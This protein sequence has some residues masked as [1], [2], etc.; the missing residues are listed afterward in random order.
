[1]SNGNNKMTTTTKGAMTK[2]IAFTPMNLDELEDQEKQIGFGQGSGQFF[3]FK[4]GKNVVRF[5]PGLNGQQAF[6]PFF[7]HFVKGAADGKIYSGLCPLKMA[8]LPCVVCT[9]I[10]RLSRGTDADRDLADDIGARS[11]VACNLI[12]RAAPDAGPQLAEIG[13]SIY[14]AVKD[15]MRTNGEDPT[16]PNDGF[17]CVIEKTGSGL[18]T[19][20]KTIAQRKNSPLHPDERQIEEW[21]MDASDLGKFLILPDEAT[22]LEKLAG[23]VIGHMLAG[24][25]GGRGNAQLAAGRQTRG[26]GQRD[27]RARVNVRQ[28][29]GTDDTGDDT[30][31]Y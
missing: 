16:D 20:Y 3:A 17:D 9:V 10:A 5:L 4:D 26:G 1:M 2:G 7:K 28:A 11:K 14:K 23:T 6:V 12:D 18:K 21:A 15:I 25:G 31:D 19:E 27:D 24:G 29:M 13:Q 8:K 30:T 22:Q